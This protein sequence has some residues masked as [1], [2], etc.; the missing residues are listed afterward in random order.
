[1]ESSKWEY[2]EGFVSDALKWDYLAKGV[3]PHRISV[4]LQQVGGLII[5]LIFFTFLIGIYF[6]IFV[7]GIVGGG[8]VAVAEWSKA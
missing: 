4:L 1:M 2:G 8:P 5:R 6:F 3:N 7:I